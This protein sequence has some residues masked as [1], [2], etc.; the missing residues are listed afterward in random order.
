MDSDSGEDPT[1]TDCQ[2]SGSESASGTLGGRKRQFSMHEMVRRAEGKRAQRQAAARR[3][4]SPSDPPPPAAVRGADGEPAPG[5][6]QLNAATLAEIK[7]LNDH[8]NTNVIRTLEAKLDSMERRLT[9]LES[10]CMDKDGTIQQLSK[11][12]EPGT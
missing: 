2:A 11:Q 3:S 5:P 9:V 6:V 12:L 10:E 7:R 1:F 4:R 8:G